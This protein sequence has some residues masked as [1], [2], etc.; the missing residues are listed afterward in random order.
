M[1]A[2]EVLG[3]SPDATDEEIKAA[4]RRLA[5]LNHPDRGGSDEEMANVNVAKDTLLGRPR[6]SPSFTPLF[7]GADVE[8]PATE[9]E[10]S[11]FAEPEPGWHRSY[12]RP[13]YVHHRETGAWR[14]ASGA[15]APPAE[16]PAAKAVARE[17]GAPKKPEYK[18]YGWKQGRRVVRVNKKLYGTEPGGRLPGGGTSRFNA[19]DRAAVSPDG[20]RMRVSKDDHTQSWD[21]IDEARRAVDAI[22][23]EEIV[24]IGE[25]RR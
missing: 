3:V 20:G 6:T 10:P 5:M 23:I 25:G 22:V 19:N 21:P 11:A 13:G 9:R 7:N 12:T 18:V 14:K 1:N 2:Y 17:P 4:W 8:A 15:E 24:A 16:K